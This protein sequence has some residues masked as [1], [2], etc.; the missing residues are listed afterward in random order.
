MTGSNPAPTPVRVQTPAASRETISQ[1]K[2]LFPLR[3]KLIVIVT[4]GIVPFFALYVAS[5]SGFEL[6][7]NT[8]VVAF[9]FVACVCLLY[10]LLDY[11]YIQPVKDIL[12]WL[13]IVRESEYKNAPVL[14]VNSQD[15]FGKM[16][17]EL[18]ASLSALWNSEQRIEALL[19]HKRD[20]TSLIEHQL[21]TPLTSLLWSF[22][23]VQIPE[24][25]RNALTKMEANVKSIVETAQIEEG[26][27]GYV[28]T[29]AIISDLLKQAIDSFK[30]QAD[31]KKITVEYKEGDG[32]PAVRVDKDRL[33]TAIGNIISNAIAYTPEGGQ[34]TVIVEPTRKGA[35]VTI[36][37]SGIGI[38]KEELPLLFNKMFRGGMARKMK[39]DGS[40]L[41]LYVAKNILEAHNA[42]LAIRS[43][44]A[45]GTEVLFEL[46]AA[47]S[48]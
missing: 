28:F 40:G 30:Q 34:I 36:R 38:S 2:A 14:P 24:T 47:Q 18:S 32:V 44:G 11:A 43:D 13:K 19:R 20:T 10:F 8:Y 27:Y 37:D 4:L 15:E 7:R 41:G 33:M 25:V 48:V 42:E 22:T 26:K 35:G 21:R 12:V 17:Q 31:A 46:P 5:Y 6:F 23:D 1:Q 9:M 29:D 39:A 3:L 16:A 45:H